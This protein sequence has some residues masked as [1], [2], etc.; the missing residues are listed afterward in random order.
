MF[1]GIIEHI[2]TIVDVNRNTLLVKVTNAI[3]E[4]ARLGESIAINGCCLTIVDIYDFKMNCNSPSLAS[5]LTL[6]FEIVKL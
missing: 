5:I 2:A 6:Q 4:K 3:I 1:I